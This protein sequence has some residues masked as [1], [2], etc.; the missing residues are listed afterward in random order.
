MEKELPYPA[1][2]KGS[3]FLLAFGILLYVVPLVIGGVEQGL[4]WRD[5]QIAFADI[6]AMA[7]LFF[8]ISTTGQLLILLGSLCLL[9]NVLVM[10]MHWKLGL[11]KAAIAAVKAP[12]ETPAAASLHGGQEEVKP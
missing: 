4:K 10:T 5:A 6:S 11:L 1:L 7:L 2:A 12:L 8:R 9:L 3:F